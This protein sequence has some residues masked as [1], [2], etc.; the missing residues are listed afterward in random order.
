MYKIR[1]AVP[2]DEDRICELFEEMLR[3]IY[4][5]EDLNGYE[6]G[7][8][9]RYWNSSE[10]IIF[11]AED[12][13]IVAFLSVEVHHESDDY[14]YID[15]L[16]LRFRVMR[17]RAYCNFKDIRTAYERNNMDY[18]IEELYKLFVN[19]GESILDE[20]T[21]DCLSPSEVNEELLMKIL[22]D[23]KDTEYGRKYGLENIHS[24]REYCQKVPLSD[25]YDYAPYIHRM[26]K[27][28]EK[29]HHSIR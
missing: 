26:I 29:K 10:D 16:L 15:D 7:Y 8:L 11:A 9:S 20:I 25:Y 5:T 27:Y 13:E 19:N 2:E 22:H 6:A 24:V 4:H 23:N 21:E 12:T 14:I 28:G 3:S 17:K 1:K 18:T